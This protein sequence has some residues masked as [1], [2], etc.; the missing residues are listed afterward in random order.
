MPRTPQVTQLKQLIIQNPGLTAHQLCKHLGLSKFELESLLVRAEAQGL[1]LS[2]SS[3]RPAGIYLFRDL[4]D[5][6]K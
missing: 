5:Q 1:L 3:E 6:D 4:A 2:Q